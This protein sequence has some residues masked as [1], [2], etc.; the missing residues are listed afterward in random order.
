MVYMLQWGC[1]IV[2]VYNSILTPDVIYCARRSRSTKPSLYILMSSQRFWPIQI[3]GVC[4]V[5]N[6]VMCV[7]VSRKFGILQIKINYISPLLK[8]YYNTIFQINYVNYS[9]CHYSRSWF[10]IYVTT[11]V[12]ISLIVRDFNIYRRYT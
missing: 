5:M 10:Q 11:N 7:E 8:Y 2:L 4:H 12:W 3:A 9:N 6:H 1:I